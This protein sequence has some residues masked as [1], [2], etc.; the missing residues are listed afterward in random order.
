M[1]TTAEVA[2]RSRADLGHD[3]LAWRAGCRNAA[4]LVTR[5]TRVST[6]EAVQRIKLGSMLAPHR[7]VLGVA[8]WRVPV[9]AAA[10]AS[11]ALGV[12]SA[13]VIVDGLASVT[14][15]CGPGEMEG[16][17]RALVATATG[18]ITDETIG[19]PGEGIAFAADLMRGQVETWKAS[20][21]P[22]GAAPKDV[23]VEP[24]TSFGFGR[25]KDGIYPFKGGATPQWR[26][27]LDTLLDSYLS[28][29]SGTSFPS[30]AEQARIEAGEVIPGADVLG[31]DRTVDQKRADLLYGI[32]DNAA[33][34]P[35]TPRMGGAAPVV[36]VHVNAVDLADDKGVGWADGV[37]APVSLKTV[38]QLICAGGI[39]KIIIGNDG[40][41]LHFGDKA[42]FFTAAQRR[43]IA[44]RD[45]T[46]IIPGCTI[47]ARWCE[48]H[49][50][51]PWQ[52]HGTTD[53]DNGVLLC[54][55]H[56]HSIDTSG[57]QIRMVNGHPEVMAPAWLGGTGQ[58]HHTT[59]HR[60]THPTK[61]R[62]RST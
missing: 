58:W 33:R 53:T 16:A 13:K 20:L 37:E 30:T 31:D 32:F 9:V 26:A 45:E 36:T 35:G 56:H 11:G 48:I 49:H 54:W 23:G 21:D 2:D 52:H 27:V 7:D 43:A 28:A 12:D 57:W 22:D 1:R 51:I 61:P 10:V 25:L 55:Y 17:E 50:V 6:K 4:D 46:C 60:A 3:G 29:R 24:R 39:Q 44:A 34:D 5:V 19:L 59:P 41:I 62:R 15:I 38:K 14:R 42:R 47:P 18:A 8:S 40:E